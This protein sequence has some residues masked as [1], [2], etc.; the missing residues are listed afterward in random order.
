MGTLFTILS[1]IGVLLFIMSVI[2]TIVFFISEEKQK[3]VPKIF[4]YNWLFLWV[5]YNG[6]VF[7]GYG[8]VFFIIWLLNTPMLSVIIGGVLIITLLWTFRKD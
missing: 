8:L 2:T 3:P 6:L 4:D 1:V 5:I 7:L